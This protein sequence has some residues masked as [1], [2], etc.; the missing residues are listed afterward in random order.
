MG[1]RD[2]GQ[3]VPTRIL[4]IVQPGRVRDRAGPAR[5]VTAMPSNRLIWT[6]DNLVALRTLLDEVDPS[7]RDRRTRGKVDLVYIDPP[8]MVN[9]DFRAGHAVDVDLGGDKTTTTRKQAAPVEMLVYKDTWRQGLDSFLTM[10]RGRLE[11]LKDLLAP[12]GSIYVHLDWHAVHYVKVLMD[13]VFGYENF[14]NEIV[15]QRTSS[16]ND[17]GKFGVIHDT[18]LYYAASSQA[19]YW[20]AP[21]LPAPPEYF[22]A[23]DFEVD[24]NGKRYRCRDLTARSHGGDSGR[25][26]WRG[27]RPPHG[28]MWAYASV[29]KLEDLLA[30]KRIKFTKNGFPRLKLYLDDDL[31]Q[32]VQSIWADDAAVNAGAAER[33]GFP[34]QKPITLLERIICASCPPAGLVLDCFAGSGTTA[35]AAERL[36]RNWIAID[37][38]KYAVHVAR[39]RLLQLH[40]QPQPPARARFEYVEC[41]TCKHVNRKPKPQR[42]PGPFRVEPFTVET[43][44]AYPRAEA[45]RDLQTGR[46]RAEMIRIFGGEP[47]ARA[48]LLHGKKGN[49][50]IHVGPLD[51]PVSASQA[52]NIARAAQRTPCKAATILSADFETLSANER[53]EIQTCTKVSVVVRL[54]PAQAIDEVRRRIEGRKPSSGASIE[55]MAVPTFYSPLS[56]VLAA[57]V[58]GRT[59]NLALERCEV[60][61]ESF[62]AS[63]HP[64]GAARKKAEAEQVKWQVRERTL[65][66]WLR[67]AHAWRNFVDFWAVDWDYPS[68]WAPDGQPIFQ[69][70]WQSFR[71]RQ[72]KHD[73]LAFTAEFSYP[74][75]GRHAIA[76]KV[77]DVFGN[78]GFA[79]V[80]VDVK[81][82]QDE[83]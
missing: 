28:R 17:P 72:G 27:V 37:S 70:A 75:P 65:Q 58:S 73:S 78:D 82:N 44:G 32:P 15:W 25:F 57:K 38:S 34:N 81:F 23:H 43:I 46:F 30:Q 69:A 55:S 64:K 52:W 62:L 50:W 2:A 79:T 63:Q 4:E 45:C 77:T 51:G 56:I 59:V 24:E 54:I 76:A 47:V 68:R 66:E 74:Q 7:T 49:F 36:G 41:D 48:P 5:D 60:D 9:T 10:L 42:S 1:R 8:F 3:P 14:R 35:E 71:V 67:K 22:A 26:E 80:E 61:G 53:A 12:A 19:P 20:G 83:G 29:E 11:L 18:L 31:T 39:K 21:T 40:G 13:E 6:S 33:L 16:H